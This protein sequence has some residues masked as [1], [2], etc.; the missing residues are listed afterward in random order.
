MDISNLAPDLGHLL[1]I[2]PVTLVLLLGLL[3]RLA[4]IGSRKI[5]D[6]WTGVWHVLRQIC[7]VIAV[8]PSSSVTSGVTIKDVAK[9]ALSRPDVAQS[10]AD[11]L[12][13]PVSEVL[14]KDPANA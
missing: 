14:P 7:V 4:V 3:N 11:D 2:N 1:G 13:K 8:D 12:G 5:P 9:N 6:D 10:V